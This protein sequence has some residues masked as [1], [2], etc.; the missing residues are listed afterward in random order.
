MNSDQMQNTPQLPEMNVNPL[1]EVTQQ[2]LQT[3]TQIP[4][5]Q[6]IVLPA[7]SQPEQQAPNPVL[8]FFQ[9][10]SAITI[11][12]SGQKQELSFLQMYVGCQAPQF[13]Q[14]QQLCGCCTCWF[15]GAGLC[16]GSL[17]GCYGNGR[18]GCVEVGVAGLAMDFTSFLIYGWVVACI[19]GLKMMSQ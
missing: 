17:F 18:S 14:M 2:P 10:Q 4:I 6:P 12:A 11:V 1:V 16:C 13:E 8:Q 5:E 9:T 3:E 15:A 7:I 19:V